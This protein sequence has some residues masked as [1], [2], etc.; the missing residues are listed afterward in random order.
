MMQADRMIAENFARPDHANRSSRSR[1]RSRSRLA[2]QLFSGFASALAGALLLT[3]LLVPNS[4]HAQRLVATVNDAPVTD[5]DVR[6]RSRLLRVLRQNATPASAMES[7]IEERLKNA[8]TKKY[9]I[10]PTDQQILAYAG[11]DGDKRKIP[12]QRFAYALQRGGIDQIHWK[13]YYRAQLAWDTLIGA[14]YKSVNVSA[15][16]VDAELDRRGSK[17]NKTEYSLQQ[18]VLVVPRS[19]GGGAYQ[20]RLREANGLRARFNDC[21]AGTALARGLRDIAIQKR[22]T[23]R[24]ADLPPALAKLLDRTPVGKLTAPQRGVNGIEMIAVC[25]KSDRSGRIAAGQDIRNEMLEK[26]LKVHSDRRYKELREK[27][28]II[29]K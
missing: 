24:A 22:I 14:L 12:Q 17:V 9:T 2:R 5:Y 10:N 29:R 1:S 4:A 25:S 18:V 15:R 23:R 19:A 20:G 16:E 11:R 27:A 21:N 28:I 13:E 7:L 8:E 3:F 6:M 26:K